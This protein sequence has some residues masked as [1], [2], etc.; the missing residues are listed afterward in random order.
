VAKVNG[1]F[2]FGEDGLSP[3]EGARGTPEDF[4]ALFAWAVRAAAEDPAWPNVLCANLRLQS[5]GVLV[6][7][8]DRRGMQDTR[9]IA[10][11]IRDAAGDIITTANTA[12]L[13]AETDDARERLAR[14]GLSA[15]MLGTAL[16]LALS[17]TAL[18]IARQCRGRYSHVSLL[19]YQARNVIAASPSEVGRIDREIADLGEIMRHAGLP[20]IAWA[21]R[22][23]EGDD[24]TAARGA[25]WAETFREVVAGR[26]AAEGAE[27]AFRQRATRE[28][29][30]A[31]KAETR[32]RK[33]KC[34][35]AAPHDETLQRR[36]ARNLRRAPPGTVE[37]IVEQ[38]GAPLTVTA[39]ELRALAPA[40][41]ARVRGRRIV[42]VLVEHNGSYAAAAEALGMSEAALRQRVHRA[43]GATPRK[44]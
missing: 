26:V 43:R 3:P 25:A 11:C 13:L 31:R 12:Y 38:D 17:R 6:G 8:D 29:D 20:E 10:Q 9:P 30:E 7:H 41:F 42:E 32:E 34:E 21:S 19:A 22:G 24:V 36:A 23:L 14:W 44:N 40:L 15:A 27:L 4:R 28:L 2:A 16:V 37:A 33:V 39:E 1:A 5:E 18:E 35:G